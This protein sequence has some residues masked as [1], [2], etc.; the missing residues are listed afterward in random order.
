MIA[1]SH[2]IIGGATAVTIGT[3]SQNPALGLAAG[4][5]SHLI[6][7]S[8][9]HLDTPPNAK[10]IGRDIV[11]DKNLYVFA[12]IDSL[13]AFLATLT[14]WYIKY[15]LDFASVFAWGALGGYLPDLADNFPLWNKQIRILPFFRQ[16][17]EFHMWIHDNWKERFPMPAYWPLGVLTQLVTVLPCLYYLIK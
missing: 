14:I 12:I 6:C 16:F 5:A 8:L 11:W 13:I 1:T 2:V 7:D 10:F 3:I 9:P 4:I 17:H 15:H